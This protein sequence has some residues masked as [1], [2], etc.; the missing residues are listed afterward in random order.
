[1]NIDI[2]TLYF[3]SDQAIKLAGHLPSQQAE[4]CARAA[5]MLREIAGI[6]VEAQIK[7]KNVVPDPKP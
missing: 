3:A 6:L 1:M 2:E 5:H 7:A 4:G